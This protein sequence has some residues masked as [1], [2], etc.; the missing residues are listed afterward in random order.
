MAVSLLSLDK[1]AILVSGDTSPRYLKDIENVYKT[2]RNYYGYP[3]NNI[4]VV[5][6]NNLATPAGVPLSRIFTLP[7]DSTT[8][9]TFNTYFSQFVAAANTA[10]LPAASLSDP[11]KNSRKA[12]DQSTGFVYFTG[13]GMNQNS[14]YQVVIG[15][16]GTGTD[17][18]YSTLD[19]LS[20]LLTVNFLLQIVMQQNYSG[21][22]YDN[23]FTGLSCD[24]SI[25]Y[26]CQNNETTSGTA[27]N[28][29][30]MTSIWVQAL[31]M[32]TSPT[33]IYAGK[34]AD[35]LPAPNDN[36]ADN[37]ISLEKAILYVTSQTPGITGTA[38]Y[39]FLGS[40]EKH[41]LGMPQLLIRD[42][43]P[44]YWISPDV[45]LSHP[46]VAPDFL[47]SSM[48]N[49]M[50]EYVVDT[51][52]DYNNFIHVCV[53]NHGTHPVRKFH[54]GG[55]VFLSGCSGP[56]NSDTALVTNADMGGIL[57]PV[58]CDS[59]VQTDDP[60]V[61]RSFE[62]VFYQVHFTDTNHRCLRGKAIL[63]DSTGIDFNTLAWDILGMDDEAQRNIDFWVTKKSIPQGTGKKKRVPFWMGNPLMIPARLTF[64]VP[65]EVHKISGMVETSFAFINDKKRTKLSLPPKELNKIHGFTADLKPGQGTNIEVEFTL[66]EKFFLKEDVV[67]NFPIVMEGRR[68]SRH[69]WP[70]GFVI[71]PNQTLIGGVTIVLRSGS[72]DVSGKVLQKGAV[73]PKQCTVT[74]TSQDGDIEAVANTDKGGC[75]EIHGMSPGV[76]R[77]HAVSGEIKSPDRLLVLKSGSKKEISID[78]M[79]K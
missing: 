64:M 77:I 74:V 62:H 71:P 11:F 4:W 63:Y 33:G 25:T 43:S 19:L 57:C 40:T 39:K 24:G 55:I 51:G 30:E 31:Q 38:Q 37:L 10:P 3:E 53:R 16:D 72:A 46:D 23:F 36:I 56:G 28:G 13:V 42:G 58:P 60:P 45:Y 1:Y 49:P 68:N 15:K 12:G 26:S 65:A 66:T 61:I 69:K 67:L 14:D 9:D 27:A 21:G 59:P 50:S 7:S 79:H 34:F 6:G 73:P 52:T 78:L 32:V 70:L 41:Y 75:F 8:K 35:E 29:S 76:W 22:F 2:I 44:T 54:V 18:L 47:E 17:V 5:L 20:Q 48:D